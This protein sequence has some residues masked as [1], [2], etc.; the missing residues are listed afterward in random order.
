MAMFSVI[1]RAPLRLSFVTALAALTALA[2]GAPTPA[3]AARKGK[4]CARADAR[5]ART[6]KGD[7][8][9]DGVSNCRERRV[10]RTSISDP[11]SDGDGLE[12]GEEVEAGCDAMD[13]DS[14][15]DGLSDGDDPSPAPPPVQ[16]MEA[17]L[18]ALTCPQ[19]DAPGSIAALGV[20]V[21]LD[22][23]TEFEDA[24]CA[25]LAELF[26]AEGDVFVEIEILED[27]AGALR[28]I[29][30]EVE[31][32]D[33]GEGHDGDDHDGDDEDHDGEDEDGDG[34]DGE[35]EDG[36]SEDGADE[37]DSEDGE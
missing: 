22:A 19:E 25:E 37:G 5:L 36:D 2:L 29:E 8:D 10:L 13:P 18:D 32:E 21:A 6:G 31:G 16:E 34:H 4:A 9:G 17:L 30:V 26:A 33:E 35:G 1:S 23:E 28:A 7:L 20:S 3:A 11:D 24:S 12:D 14:D 27:E 15:D